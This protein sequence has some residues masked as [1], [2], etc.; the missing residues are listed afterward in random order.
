MPDYKYEGTDFDKFSESCLETWCAAKST[1]LTAEN[2]DYTDGQVSG[3]NY[4]SIF[5]DVTL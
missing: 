3:Y 2:T 1:Q 5:V 4:G